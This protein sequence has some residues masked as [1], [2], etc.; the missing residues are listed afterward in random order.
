MSCQ[1]TEQ[2]HLDERDY[3]FANFKGQSGMP[4]IKNIFLMLILKHTVLKN[5]ILQIQI[6]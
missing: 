5:V 2:R 6:L 3:A 4:E 1:V